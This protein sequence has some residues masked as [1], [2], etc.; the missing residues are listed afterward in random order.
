MARKLLNLFAGIT[1]AIAIAWQAYNLYKQNVSQKNPVDTGKLVRDL[2][3][4]EYEKQHAALSSVFMLAGVSDFRPQL[5]RAGVVESLINITKSA[6][7]KDLKKEG[8]PISLLTL[9]K[10]VKEEPGQAGKLL[11]AK[12]LPRLLKVI[13]AGQMRE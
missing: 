10:I 7:L 6:S 8:L 4:G 9:S 12:L 1:V 5:L 11:E 3:S 2:G 13:K